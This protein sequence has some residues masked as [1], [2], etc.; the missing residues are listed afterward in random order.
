MRTY[1]SDIIAEANGSLDKARLRHYE[2][3]TSLENT[4]R[5]AALFGLVVESVSSK[6]LIPIISFSQELARSRFD[7][8]FDLSEVQTAYH[9]LEETLWRHISKHV[10]SE[11]L[12]SAF[13]LTSTVLGAAKD[14]LA[15]EYVSLA[16]K[17]HLHSLDLSALFRGT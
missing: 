17:R 4:E 16:S 7:Q 15:L 8:G 14:A 6:N 13:G 1:Q 5:L 10:M 12:P 2:Q 3:S 9:V 11:D